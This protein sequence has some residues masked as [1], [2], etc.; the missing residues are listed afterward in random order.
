MNFYAIQH[1]VGKISDDKAL[2]GV[3]ILLFDQAD[4]T[5]LVEFGIR[6]AHHLIEFYHFPVHPLFT[7]AFEAMRQ[8]QN[9]QSNYHRARKLAGEMQDLAR[10]EPDPLT[11]RFYRTIAQAAA[12]PHVK[13]HGLWLTDFGISLINRRFPN[14]LEAITQERQVQIDLLKNLIE[15]K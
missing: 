9:H 14:D 8:W 7:E 11:A 5:T 13:F 1:A 2:R 12:I 4:H 3:F 10:T 15:D 6:Y